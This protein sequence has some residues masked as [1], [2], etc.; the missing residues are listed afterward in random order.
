MKSATKKIVRASKESAEKSMDSH[1]KKM[2]DKGWM[3]DKEFGG[4]CGCKYE[5]VTWFYKS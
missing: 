4:D 3:V 1:I 2:K 5:R